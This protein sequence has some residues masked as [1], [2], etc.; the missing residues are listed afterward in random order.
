MSADALSAAQQ[1]VA[2]GIVQYLASH[3]SAVDTIDG[4]AQW[5][6]L[7]EGR[8]RRRTDVERALAWLLAQ[9]LICETRR[10]GVPPYYRLNPQ[11]RDR[12]ATFS[13]EGRDAP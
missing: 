7:R 11:H 2:Q 5:W 8:E 10:P 9:D 12:I 4:I 3:P 6:L 13:G 1:E